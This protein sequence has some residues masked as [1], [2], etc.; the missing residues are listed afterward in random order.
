MKKYIP[1]HQFHV[2]RVV[3]TGRLAI[4]FVN[5]ENVLGNSQIIITIGFVYNQPVIKNKSL[6]V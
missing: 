6:K 2:N 1:S 4:I 3:F 5:K